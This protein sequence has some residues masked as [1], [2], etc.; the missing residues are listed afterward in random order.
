MISV[1]LSAR[2]PVD[3]EYAA[4]GLV[5]PREVLRDV[6]ELVV[7]NDGAEGGEVGEHDLAVRSIKEQRPVKGHHVLEVPLLVPRRAVSIV[8]AE[9]KSLSPGQARDYV[10]PIAYLVRTNVS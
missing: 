6:G 9:H 7:V 3:V 1:T 5:Q 8:T 2:V 10:E 4:T